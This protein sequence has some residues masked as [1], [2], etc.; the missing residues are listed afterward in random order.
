MLTFGG[1]VHYCLGTHLA[2]PELTEALR[3][4]TQRM[5]DPRRSQPAQWKAMTAIS[6]PISVPPEFDAG[7]G[8]QPKPLR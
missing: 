7:R 4:I 3:I 5:P 2:R 6:G 1:G 8:T